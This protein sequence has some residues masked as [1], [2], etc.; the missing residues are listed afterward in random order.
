M[1]LS[2]IILYMSCLI[3]GYTNTTLAGVINER[4]N[5][6]Y[7]HKPSQSERTRIF[8]HTKFKIRPLTTVSGYTIPELIAEERDDEDHTDQLLK[9]GKKPA[10]GSSLTYFAPVITAL[11][12]NLFFI[13]CNLSPA[14][15]R[16][17]LLCVL[18]V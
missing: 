4:D 1:R 15:D 12:D 5:T 8:L 17:L 14:T 16:Y 18:R 9:Q 2:L 13:S 6:V 11:P 10:Y 7:N 3:F